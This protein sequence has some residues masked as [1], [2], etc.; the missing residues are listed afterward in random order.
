MKISYE[1]KIITN[2]TYFEKAAFPISFGTIFEGYMFT[3]T[4]AGGIVYESVK[5]QLAQTQGQR[6]GGGGRPPL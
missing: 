3:F 4:D 6:Y 5:S 1:L 2:D